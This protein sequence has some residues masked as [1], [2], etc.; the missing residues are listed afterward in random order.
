MLRFTSSLFALVLLAGTSATL[1]AD[2]NVDS[3]QNV[4]RKI[5]SIGCHTVNTICYATLE[6]TAV[7]PWACESSSIR[8]LADGPNGEAVTRQLEMAFLHQKPVLFHLSSDCF[9]AQP[10]FPTFDYHFVLSQ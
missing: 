3:A 6:G 1:T 5:V 7:G 8:W 9:S 10:Q 4:T 2:E